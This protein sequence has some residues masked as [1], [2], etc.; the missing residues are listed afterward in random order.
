[1]TKEKI[2]EIIFT[3]FISFMSLIAPLLIPFLLICIFDL[4]DFV[5][6]VR[7]S[8]KEGQKFTMSMAMDKTINKLTG[9]FAALIVAFIL[10]K[11]FLNDLPVMKAIEL[12]I[13]LTQVQSIRENVQTLLNFDILKDTYNLLKR[14]K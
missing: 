8:K 9:Q 14:K 5:T 4:I 13:V 11:I 2:Q 1:M 10:Q 6:G 3:A 12:A 7:A